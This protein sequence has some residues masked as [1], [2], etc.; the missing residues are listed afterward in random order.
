MLVGSYLAE[1]ITVH[2]QQE[3]NTL[4]LVETINTGM[5]LFIQIDKTTAYNSRLT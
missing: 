4:V 2:K 1:H 5:S 3:D